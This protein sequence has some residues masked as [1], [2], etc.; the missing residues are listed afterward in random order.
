MKI[1]KSESGFVLKMIDEPIKG[2]K[3]EITLSLAFK[4][5]GEREKSL[6]LEKYPTDGPTAGLLTGAGVIPGLGFATAVLFKQ[7]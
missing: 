2:W 1:S 6:T 7:T 5:W 3:I 4:E